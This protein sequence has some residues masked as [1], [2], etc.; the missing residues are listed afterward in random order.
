T[1][2]QRDLGMALAIIAVLSSAVFYPFRIRLQRN[3]VI[4]SAVLALYLGSN[5]LIFGVMNLEWIRRRTAGFAILEVAVFC[6][7]AWL[8]LLNRSGEAIPP[9]LPPLSPDDRDGLAQQEREL[10]E[11]AETIQD[12]ARPARTRRP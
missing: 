2:A 8:I 4:H 9:K 1:L 10:M 6:Y 7:S 3:T 5:S 12:G 11:V